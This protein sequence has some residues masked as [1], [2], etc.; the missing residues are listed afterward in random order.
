[1]RSFELG[2]QL[3]VFFLQAAAVGFRHRKK[4]LQRIRELLL[5]FLLGFARV[6]DAIGEDLALRD[7]ELLHRVVVS[8]RAAGDREQHKGNRQRIQQRFH[9][10][11]DRISALK[12]RDDATRPPAA[13]PSSTERDPAVR[14]RAGAGKGQAA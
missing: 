6:F 14:N 7:P 11:A 4:A 13:N 9:T 5:R 8:G 3:V 12:C 10:P 2:V 1:M